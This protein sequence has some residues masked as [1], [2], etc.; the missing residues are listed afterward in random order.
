LKGGYPNHEE[1][2]AERLTGKRVWEVFKGKK[3]SRRRKKEMH[4]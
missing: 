3:E 2:S 4:L 1:V